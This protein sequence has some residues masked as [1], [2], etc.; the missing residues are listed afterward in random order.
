M[1]GE[2]LNYDLNGRTLLDKILRGGIHG[3]IFV[4]I[5]NGNRPYTIVSFEPREFKAQS[6]DP[7]NKGDILVQLH[8]YPTICELNRGGAL[9][10]QGS[11]LVDYFQDR[12]YSARRICK[13]TP[14]HMIVDPEQVRLFM[15]RYGIRRK[16]SIAS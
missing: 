8:G 4:D 11:L 2:I 1:D 6:Q 13:E 5:R 15:E 12:V 16:L 9:S 10:R 7:K 14:E 3:V